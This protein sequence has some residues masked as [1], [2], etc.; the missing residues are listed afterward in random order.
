MPSYDYECDPQKGGCGNKFELFQ[1]ISD[2]VK[3]KCPKCKK[4]KLR[5]LIG[6]PALIFKGEGWTPRNH[7]NI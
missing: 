1:K 2:A 6:V 3:K 5:R 7:S 4:S